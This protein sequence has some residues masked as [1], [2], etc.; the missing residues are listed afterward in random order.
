MA[1]LFDDTKRW[2]SFKLDVSEDY[3]STEEDISPSSLQASNG[4]EKQ[5]VIGKGHTDDSVGEKAL[6]H[7]V[8]ACSHLAVRIQTKL[9]CLHSRS[10]PGCSI[11]VLNRNAISACKL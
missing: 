8:S 6:R 7:R 4:H 5:Q 11:T 10:K 3:F 2:G 1:R 9:F